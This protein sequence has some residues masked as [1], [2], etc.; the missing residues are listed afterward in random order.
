MPIKTASVVK[1]FSMLA[2]S[3]V[4]HRLKPWLGQTKDYKISICCF[5]A[6]HA[7]LS[8]RAKT[9]WLWI[10]IMCPRGAANLPADCCFS[11]LAQYKYNWSSTKPTSSSSH[12]NCSC[13]RHDMA[14]KLL[15]WHQITITHS[16]NHISCKFFVYYTLMYV[17]I[18]DSFKIET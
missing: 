9:G 3:V 10:R 4:D 8:V 12:Q 17:K 2:T 13:S 15:A 18:I 11:E 14:E 1:W 16:P 7:A 6:K 5:S